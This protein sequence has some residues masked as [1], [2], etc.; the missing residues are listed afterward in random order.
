MNS[1]QRMVTVVLLSLATFS[2]HATDDVIT[3]EE[4]TLIEQRMAELAEKY[5]MPGASISPEMIEMMEI[6]CT[7]YPQCKED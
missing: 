6:S 3:S 7:P 5:N 1:I 4:Q 2:I